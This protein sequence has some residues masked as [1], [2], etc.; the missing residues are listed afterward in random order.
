MANHDAFNLSF[1][2]LAT[3]LLF[4]RIRVLASYIVHYCH[5]LVLSGE[6]WEDTMGDQHLDGVTSDDTGSAMVSVRALDVAYLMLLR[7]VASRHDVVT[8]AFLW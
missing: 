7:T 6:T 5:L 1:L 8:H 3:L 4:F 2:L